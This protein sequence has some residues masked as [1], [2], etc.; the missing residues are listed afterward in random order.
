MIAS[1]IYTDLASFSFSSLL[2]PLALDPSKKALNN[3]K[4]AVTSDSPEA[5]AA[6]TLSGTKIQD[7]ASY[8]GELQMSLS[9]SPQNLS[10]VVE[11]FNRHPEPQE[12]L[13]A[14]I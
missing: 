11:T 14:M 5:A 6:M 8:E 9:N 3:Y 7:K 2:L 1:H 12:S 4:V 13:E 10:S